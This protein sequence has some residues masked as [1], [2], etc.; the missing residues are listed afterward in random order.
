MQLTGIAETD[1]SKNAFQ[2][3]KE[4]SS[5]DIIYK[6]EKISLILSENASNPKF[7]LKRKMDHNS[8]VYYKIQKTTFT[9]F[10]KNGIGKKE[11][12]VMNSF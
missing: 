7:H 3:Q 11:Y 10:T 9:K 2:I 12:A 8:G 4:S 1:L 5:F 6:D